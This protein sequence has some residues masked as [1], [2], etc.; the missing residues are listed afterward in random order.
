M[1]VHKDFGNLARNIQ[2]LNGTILKAQ[3][4]NK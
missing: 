4:Y 2:L 3:I 1:P